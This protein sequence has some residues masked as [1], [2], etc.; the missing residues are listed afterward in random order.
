M[1]R[2]QRMKI[3]LF[4]STDMLRLQRILPEFNALE[5]QH[6]GRIMCHVS[7]ALEAQHVG[8]ITCHVSLALEAQHVGRITC[9]VSL[10]LEAQHV[11]S[12]NKILET[13]FTIPADSHFYNYFQNQS[14]LLLS[15]GVVW[16]V[17]GSFFKITINK[18]VQRTELF[19]AIIL[20][21][22]L[23]CS[24]PNYL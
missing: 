4:C 21:K 10:A 9:H 11:G 6:V 7:L 16:T 8:R 2:L 14:T 1:L 12:R 15:E 3:I 24:A 19:V 23:R 20:P 22:C 18:K 13:Y 17:F 5:A